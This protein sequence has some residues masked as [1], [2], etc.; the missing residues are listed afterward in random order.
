MKLKNFI[1]E[2]IPYLIIILAV[3]L[4]RTFIITPGIIKGTSMENTLFSKDLVLINKIGL[5]FG[6]DRYDIV[7][8]SYNDN[9]LVKRVI[10]L[11][12]EEVEYANNELFINGVKQET[13]IDFEY[14]S[15]FKM[16]TGEN[17][18]I[19]LGDNRD[20]SKDSRLIGPIKKEQINGIVDFVLFPFTRFGTI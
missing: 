2:L 15:S 5:N 4:I 17:E 18:Y 20:V 3:V 8:L 1:K 7:S 11:P 12:N 16:T 14:T 6:I 13:P 10:G 19:V 9:T